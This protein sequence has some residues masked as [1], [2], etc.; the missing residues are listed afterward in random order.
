MIVKRANFLILVVSMMM[1]VAACDKKASLTDDRKKTIYA[2]GNTIAQRLEPFNLKGDD[3]EVLKKGLED[4]ILKKKPEVDLNT[5][6]MKIQE[7]AMAT[8][9]AQAAEEK[10]AAADFLKAAEGEAGAVKLP[11]GVI[12]KSIKEGDGASPKA[13]DTVKVHYHGTLR[14]GKVFDSS[15]QRGEPATFPLNG[16]IPCWTEGVQKMKVHGKAKLT[17]PSEAA[18]GDRGA[19]GDIKPGAALTFEVELLDI[20]KDAGKGKPDAKKK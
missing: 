7:M 18:Y 5:Y 2:L 1:V 11:S 8:M 16:V 20:V 14:D 12:I 13:T 15:V 3:I 9:Q 19:G 10:K 4:G 6:G 17:C